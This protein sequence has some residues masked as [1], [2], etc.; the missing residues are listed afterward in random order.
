[1]LSW[2]SKGKG[3]QALSGASNKAHWRQVIGDLEYLQ[4]VHARSH[5]WLSGMEPGATDAE[6]TERF[7]VHFHQVMQA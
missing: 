3:R 6:F 2:F 7:L 1:M 5:P 4:K